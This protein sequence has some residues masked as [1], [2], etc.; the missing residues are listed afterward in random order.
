MN[1]VIDFILH[2]F[3]SSDFSSLWKS[4]SWTHF[5]G[6]LYIISDLMIGTAYFVIPTLI[7]VYIRKQGKKVHFNGLYILF[8]T[9]IFI[10]GLTYLI[11]ALMFW[12]PIFRFSALLR[13]ITAVISWVTIYYVVKVL[14]IAFSL[15][16]PKELQDEIDRRI[17][18]EQELKVKNERL[19]EAEQT[20]KLGYGH[21]DIHRDYIELSEMACNILGISPDAVI[22]KDVLV[23]QVHPADIKFVEDSIKKNLKSKNFQEFYFRVVTKHMYVIHV[24]IKGDVIKNALGEPIMV[25]GTVQDVSELRRHMQRIE[26][27]NKRLK[28][29][30]WVQSHRMRSPVASIL[31]MADLFNFDEPDDPMNAEIITNIK[32]L[33]VK[34]DEMIHEVDNLTREKSR[35]S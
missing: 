21:W 22:T 33:S 11:N 16:S 34:L 14:P 15:K 25:R 18:V 26:L 2:L 9:F 5:H 35:H 29:I 19:L 31:G 20:A 17:H 30:A 4:G 27:Q 23:E 3:K 24:L 13:F 12:V 8:A 32:E 6:W 1:Q 10:S 28:K 7:F